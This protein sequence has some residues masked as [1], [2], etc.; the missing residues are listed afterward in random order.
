MPP[1]HGCAST[2]TLER[3]RKP[4]GEIVALTAQDL[5]PSCNNAGLQVTE[6]NFSCYSENAVSGWGP[7]PKTWASHHMMD[8][9]ARKT[10][11]VVRVLWTTCRP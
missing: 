2:A 10:G 1:R 5:A 9:I 11:G 7:V 3:L 8:E 4:A 6:A